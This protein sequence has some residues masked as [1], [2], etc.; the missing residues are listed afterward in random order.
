MTTGKKLHSHETTQSIVIFPSSIFDPLGEKI[1]ITANLWDSACTDL[2]VALEGVFLCWLTSHYT[3]THTHTPFVDSYSTTLP[4]Q[5]RT[6]LDRKSSS[7]QRKMKD[8][9]KMAGVHTNTRH[10]FMGFRDTCARINTCTGAAWSAD[11]VIPL[12]PHRDTLFS[13]NCHAV[14]FFDTGAL[15]PSMAVR[16]LLSRPSRHAPPPPSFSRTKPTRRR[17]KS[18]RGIKRRAR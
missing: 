17:C 4:Q 9:W 8:D 12:R 16:K 5:V 10:R 11:K 14:C 3:H 15:T 18:D 13:S 2:N 1:N 7:Q 6:C